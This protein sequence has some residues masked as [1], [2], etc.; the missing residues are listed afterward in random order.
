M[1][2]TLHSVQI[3]LLVHLSLFTITPSLP[4]QSLILTEAQEAVAWSWERMGGCCT[5][6][7]TFSSTTRNINRSGLNI[8]NLVA[9]WGIILLNKLFWFG[10]GAFLVNIIL[11]D[12]GYGLKILAVRLSMFWVFFCPCML[13]AIQI[14]SLL[15]LFAIFIWTLANFKMCS[16]QFLISSFLLQITKF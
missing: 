3:N 14:F 6:G 9:S 4:H 7:A 2:H 11:E 16:G 13:R 15:M 1:K 10:T 12:K 8:W 5:H